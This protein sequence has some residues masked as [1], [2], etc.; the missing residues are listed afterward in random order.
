MHVYINT[1][2]SIQTY[3][4]IYIYIY[5]ILSL[6]LSLSLFCTLSMTTTRIHTYTHTP[7]LSNIQQ[8]NL[9][10]G[11]VRIFMR[12]CSDVAPKFLFLLK[13]KI[14]RA[15]QC[16]DICNTLIGRELPNFSCVEKKKIPRAGQCEDICE[17]LLW[18]EPPNLGARKVSSYPHTAPRAESF[19]F[20]KKAKYPQ[21]KVFRAPKSEE[22]LLWCEPSKQSFANILTLPRARNLFFFHTRKI[23]DICETLLWC[24]NLVCENNIDSARGA[25][26]GYL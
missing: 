19:F 22:T 15:G 8:E 24:E 10:W 12:L 2:E 25:E 23:E 9:R 11:K 6:S 20:T 18:W 4:Y 26:W 7:F 17:T 16:E 5:D 1:C 13:K 21:I 14:P 3:I